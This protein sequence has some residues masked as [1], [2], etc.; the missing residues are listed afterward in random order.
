M[1]IFFPFK[2]S[3]QDFGH[4][5]LA[6]LSVDDDGDYLWVHISL[7]FFLFPVAILVM[8]RFSV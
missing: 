1:I 8:R 5:T 4:T 7:S 3:E 6:N 2:G